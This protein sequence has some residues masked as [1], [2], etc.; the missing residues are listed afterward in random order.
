MNERVA[1]CRKPLHIATSGGDAFIPKT[2]SGYPLHEKSSWDT[3]LGKAKQRTK[4]VFV[5]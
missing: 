3:S 4:T 1:K 5:K 2:I